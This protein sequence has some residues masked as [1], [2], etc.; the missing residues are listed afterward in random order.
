M[1]VNQPIK[2]KA[3]K[4]KKQRKVGRNAKYCQFYALTHRR[5]KNKVIRLKK[6]LKYFPTDHCAI[7]AMDRYKSMV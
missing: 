4:G 3:K 6:H 5:E 2:Q 7:N 1:P